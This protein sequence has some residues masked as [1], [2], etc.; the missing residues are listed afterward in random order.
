MG[1]T[2][3]TR[4]KS[5]AELLSF[6]WEGL[7]G[8]VGI[9]LTALGTTSGLGLQSGRYSVR[10]ADYFDRLDFNEANRRP[11]FFAVRIPADAYPNEQLKV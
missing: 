6:Q 11:A 2:R 3:G 4:P 8:A 9:E 7:V 10:V 5:R 1:Y